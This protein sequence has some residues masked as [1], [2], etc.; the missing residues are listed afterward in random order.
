MDDVD[1]KTKITRA[2]LESMCADVFERVG[3]VVEQAVSA[4]DM[5]LGEIP[6]VIVVGGGT[7][8]PKV[9]DELMTAVKRYVHPFLHDC[10]PGTVTK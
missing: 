7:R 8:I 5:S 10:N 9:Q 2:E 6:N 4:A 3:K 1:F